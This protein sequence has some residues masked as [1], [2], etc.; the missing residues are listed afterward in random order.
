MYVINKFFINNKVRHTFRFCIDLN[1]QSHI[2]LWN[3]YPKSAQ[4]SSKNTHAL[5][6]PM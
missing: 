6:I 2:S 4:L 5:R 3:V 1:G